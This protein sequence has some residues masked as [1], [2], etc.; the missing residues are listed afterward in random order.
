MRGN[1]GSKR[2]ALRERETSARVRESEC[3]DEERIDEDEDV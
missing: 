3:D 2:F 1:H